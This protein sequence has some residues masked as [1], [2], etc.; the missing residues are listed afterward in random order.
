[1]QELLGFII[2]EIWWIWGNLQSYL[3]KRCRNYCYSG[4]STPSNEGDEM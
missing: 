2:I 3:L 1:M 4:T